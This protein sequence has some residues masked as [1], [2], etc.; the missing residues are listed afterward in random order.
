M[1]DEQIIRDVAENVLGLHGP[2]CDCTYA[3]LDLGN[4]FCHDCGKDVMPE[5]L[6]SDAT[7][8]AVLDKMVETHTCRIEMYCKPMQWYVQF[9]PFPKRNG[10]HLVTSGDGV[11]HTD[12]DRRRAICLAA[13][14]ACAILRAEL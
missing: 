7:A 5:A 13:L 3:P 10:A 1:T 11:S 2:W 9:I 6:H 14:K 12:G 8:C 4:G